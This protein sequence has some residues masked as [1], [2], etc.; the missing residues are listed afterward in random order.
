MTCDVHKQNILVGFVDVV[1]CTPILS[2]IYTHAHAHTH[3]HFST[4]ADTFQVMLIC[5]YICIACLSS[6]GTRLSH[7][8]GQHYNFPNLS[9]FFLSRKLPDLYLSCTTLKLWSMFVLYRKSYTTLVGSVML[10]YRMGEI[11]LWS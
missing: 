8:F 1:L 7:I 10:C 9:E 3:T 6:K 2:H 4:H 11:E 5:H